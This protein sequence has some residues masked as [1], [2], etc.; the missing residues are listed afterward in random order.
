MNVRDQVKKDL[1]D[2]PFPSFWGP[3]AGVESSR[4]IAD[5]SRWIENRHQPDLN[6]IYLPHLDY[7]LQR[8]GPHDPKCRKALSEIDEIAGSLIDFFSRERS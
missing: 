2:F 1:G 5:A 6:L 7:D 3:R 8:Y 4:W